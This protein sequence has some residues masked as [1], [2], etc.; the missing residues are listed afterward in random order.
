MRG[1]WVTSIVNERYLNAVAMSHRIL[2]NLYL[3]DLCTGLYVFSGNDF[4][5]ENAEETIP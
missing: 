2:A 1:D 5:L 4:S 3:R